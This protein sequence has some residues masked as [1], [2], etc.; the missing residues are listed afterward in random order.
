MLQ[1]SLPNDAQPFI[2]KVSVDAG[3]TALVPTFAVGAQVTVLASVSN[4]AGIP[5]YLAESDYP[6]PRRPSRMAK[7][8][9]HFRVLR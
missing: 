7:Y 5:H 8:W 3:G 9:K 6:P 1:Y 4:S 2:H